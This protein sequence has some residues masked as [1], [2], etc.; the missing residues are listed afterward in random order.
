MWAVCGADV[1]LGVWELVGCIDEGCEVGCEECVPVGD[2]LRLLGCCGVGVR[3]VVHGGGDVGAHLAGVRLD[4]LNGLLEARHQRI[5]VAR[6]SWREGEGADGRLA[7][8]A[9]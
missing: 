6:H 8:V 1:F 7:R 2:G 3:G 5:V 9:Q 4:L